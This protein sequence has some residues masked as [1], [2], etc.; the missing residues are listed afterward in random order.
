MSK[1]DMDLLREIASA[2]YAR[3][4]YRQIEQLGPASPPLAF[5]APCVGTATLQKN[6]CF[7]VSGPKDAVKMTAILRSND[8]KMTTPRR[9]Y[10]MPGTT[11][12]TTLCGEIRLCSVLECTSDDG[13]YKETDECVA[14]KMDKRKTMKH[15]HDDVPHPLAENPW[16]EVSAMEFLGR[17]KSPHVMQLIEALTDQDCLYEIM[18]YCPE[19]MDSIMKRYPQG[20]EEDRAREYFR[21]ILFAL[22][23]IHS[24]GVCHRDISTQNILVDKL[25]HCVLIDFG[26]CLRVPYPYQDDYRGEDVTDCSAG[27]TRRLIH[28]QTHCGKLRFMAPEMYKMLDFDGLSVD[29]WSSGVVLFVLLT[30]RYPY[31]RPDEN[32]PGFH[33]LLDDCYYWDPKRIPQSLSWGRAISPAAL[34]LLRGIFRADPCERLTLAQ[35]AEHP[36]LRGAPLSQ[37]KS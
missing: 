5:A 7:C 8:W 20:L 25:G 12:A 14:I 32:D 28:C 1:K 23:H 31:G 29:L 36:W 13:V 18:T 3:V 37:A 11:L 26:M 21:Q 4:T 33:D 9:A 15:L 22:H 6:N 24:H 27:T 10:I 16:K 35:V 17:D 2:P 19:N 30:G 34:D